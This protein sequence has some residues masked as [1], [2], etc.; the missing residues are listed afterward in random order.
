MLINAEREV[1]NLLNLFQEPQKLRLSQTFEKI[2]VH[3]SFS[4]KLEIK[5]IFF[6]CSLVFD[7]PVHSCQTWVSSNQAERK[8]KVKVH[9]YL[10]CVRLKISERPQILLTMA[11]LDFGTYFYAMQLPNPL[12]QLEIC[13]S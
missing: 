3:I 12:I 6:K 10:D 11:A 9:F 2:I 13:D 7:M 4:K 5:C 8:A 1:I